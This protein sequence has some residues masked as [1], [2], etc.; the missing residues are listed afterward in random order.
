M[1][2]QQF[3]YIEE[4]VRKADRAVTS[5]ADYETYLDIDSVIDW[6][7]LHELTNNSD[8]GFRRSCF[9]TKQAGGKLQMGP[10]WDFDLAFGN[11]SKDNH[12]YDTWATTGGDYLGTTWFAYLMKDARFNT[13][14]KARW[15]AVKDDLLSTAVQ[16]IDSI[17]RSLAVSQVS[18]FIRWD[19]LNK[20][21]GYQ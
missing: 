20:R 3:A 7:I 18:N 9:F 5:G 13:K 12:A 15:N 8:S 4:Y 21:A 19:I 6:I 2:A 10:V 14:L 11:F 17:S 16:D 1:S